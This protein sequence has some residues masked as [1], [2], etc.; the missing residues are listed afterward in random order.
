MSEVSEVSEGVNRVSIGYQCLSV[1]EVSEPSVK[2]LIIDK[3]KELKLN[4]EVLFTD[5]FTDTSFLKEKASEKSSIFTDTSD[6]HYAFLEA[7]E[8]ES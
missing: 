2:G 3:I 6:G 4:N 1:S 5:T 7:E 8:V